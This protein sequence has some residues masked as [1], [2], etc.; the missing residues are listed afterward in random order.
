MTVEDA[1][2]PKDPVIKFKI[3]FFLKESRYQVK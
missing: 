1:K 3:I 2:A